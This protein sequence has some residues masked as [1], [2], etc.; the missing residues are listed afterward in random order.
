MNV[1][2]R[3]E[4]PADGDLPS[5]A[6]TPPVRL[7]NAA[8]SAKNTNSQPQKKSAK[9]LR[10]TSS[11]DS[12]KG[13]RQNTDV[14][15]D[16]SVTRTDRAV[17]AAASKQHNDFAVDIRTPSN[18]PAQQQQPVS[19]ACP[20]A[21]QLQEPSTASETRPSSSHVRAEEFLQVSNL[22]QVTLP[23]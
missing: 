3:V 23:Y 13:R 16:S 18:P 20:S 4:T 21:G 11:S 19:D 8:A 2:Q 14:L 9:V 10:P 17:P 1:T 12:N 22:L 15:G 5:S 7:K 6:Q